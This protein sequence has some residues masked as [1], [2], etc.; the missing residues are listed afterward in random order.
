MPIKPEN[1]KRYPKDWKQIRA[2]VLK[3][4]SNLCEK[5]G[6]S[7]GDIGYRQD[8]GQFVCI[9]MAKD[10]EGGPEDYAGHATGYRVFQIVLTIAH[11]NHI[12]EDCG[13]PGNRPNLAAWCQRC[14]LAYDHEHH[15]RNARAT[16]RA[17]KRTA[18]LF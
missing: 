12:P 2:E 17:N 18:E 10:A 15:Q 11:K 6:V 1:A 3:H 8:N 13:T 14:H 16:R 5:C 7:N 4:A 9:V